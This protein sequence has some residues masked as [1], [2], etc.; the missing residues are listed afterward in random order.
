MSL[1]ETPLDVSPCVGI[2]NCLHSSTEHSALAMVLSVVQ[3]TLS[4]LCSIVN[5][6]ALLLMFNSTLISDTLL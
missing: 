5:V 4:R 3:L 1:K 6:V 2:L